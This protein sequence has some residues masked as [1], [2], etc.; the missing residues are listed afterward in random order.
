MPGNPGCEGQP[1]FHQPIKRKE[2]FVIVSDGLNLGDINTG[3][4][5]T[6]CYGVDW[7]TVVVFFSRKPLF[8]GGSD[9]IPILQKTG[10]AVVIKSG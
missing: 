6:G 3:N 10:G 7:E 8:L 4:L 2:R 1:G 9:D 5:Q